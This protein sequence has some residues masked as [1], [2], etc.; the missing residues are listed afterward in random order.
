MAVVEA[1]EVAAATAVASAVCSRDIDEA[2]RTVV[3]VPM[4]AATTAAA[5]M[6]A[7]IIRKKA[8]AAAAVVPTTTAART[9]KVKWLKPKE[10]NRPNAMIKVESATIAVMKRIR[11]ISRIETAI[12]IWQLPLLQ[13]MRKA[14][15]T[16]SVA[17]VRLVPMWRPT[18]KA[19]LEL[20]PKAARRPANRVVPASKAAATLTKA[21]LVP[22][23]KKTRAAVKRI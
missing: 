12:E 6:V 5:A 15:A 4:A 2:G 9:T 22:T 19:V 10:L 23:E 14:H 11:R 18:R 7:R 20:V 21:R 13:W 8:A 1:G 16:A 17:R 3:G